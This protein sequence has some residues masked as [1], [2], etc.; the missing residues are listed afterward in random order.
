[1]PNYD[2]TPDSNFGLRTTTPVISTTP[3]SAVRT[4]PTR[5]DLLPGELFTIKGSTVKRMALGANGKS[6]SI[7]MGNAKLSSTKN[8]NSSVTKIGKSAIFSTKLHL[9]GGTVKER[10]QVK[11]GEV[12]TIE[13]KKGLYAHLGTG[14]NEQGGWNYISF[15]LGGQ[16]EA[17][18]ANAHKN[19]KCVGTFAISQ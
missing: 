10:H 5:G 1:M 4:G 13:G 7:N 16:D 2:M 12:F 17:V 3:S 9:S 18:T 14:R 15:S 19:V 8:R 11:K 6:W